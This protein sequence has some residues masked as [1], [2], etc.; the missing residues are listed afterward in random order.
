MLNAGIPGFLLG[1][2]PQLLFDPVAAAEFASDPSA[3]IA[4]NNSQITINNQLEAFA[5]AHNIPFVNFFGLESSLLG[6][7]SVLV[8]GVPISLTQVGSNPQNFFIDDLHPGIVGNAIIGNLWMEAMNIAY[9]PTCSFLR[10]NKFLR[11]WTEQRIH[12]RDLLDL[13]QSGQLCRLYSGPR[14]IVAHPAGRRHRR[15]L[16]V[17]P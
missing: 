2:V 6:Q 1:S 14:A 12:R 8:G 7:S 3:A 17:L 4:L 5:A 16:R 13:G 10:I 15:C 11:R 9:R